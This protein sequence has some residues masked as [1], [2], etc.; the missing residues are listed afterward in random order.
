MGTN[1]RV[2][3]FGHVCRR[4]A[5][6][7]VLIP[8]VLYSYTKGLSEVDC[9]GKTVDD[10][11]KDLDTRYP[12]LRFRIIDETDKIRRHIMI[13]IGNRRVSSLS[14]LVEP[15]AKLSI[16]PSISGGKS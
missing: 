15:A 10:V 8:S 1:R 9:R 14:E 13:F 5:S 16:I 3:A 11:L 2:P 7:K 4:H 12:G 6:V